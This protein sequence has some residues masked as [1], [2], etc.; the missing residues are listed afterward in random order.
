MAWQIGR[1]LLRDDAV[2]ASGSMA[3]MVV[4]HTDDAKG[5]LKTPEAMTRNDAVGPG[6]R[7]RD[8]TPPDSTS[9]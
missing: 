7:G 3:A 5:V 2:C 1:D 9:G 8:G 4:S 6:S